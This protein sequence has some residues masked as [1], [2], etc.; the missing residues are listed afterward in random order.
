MLW[1]V[2]SGSSVHFSEDRS[3]FSE[4]RYFPEKERHFVQTANGTIPIQGTGTVFIK[5]W[6]NNT[7]DK[8]MMTIPCLHP[9]IYMLGIRIHLLSMGLLLK[10]NMH[11]K[12]E[13][14]TLQFIDAQSRKAKIVAISR[15]LSDMIYWVNLEVLSGEELTMHKSMH[16]MIMI[17]G[18]NDLDILGNSCLRNLN[19]VHENFQNQLRSL[20]SA[21]V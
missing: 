6:I 7:P 9:V 19:K 1:V 12:G 15:L 4:L 20:K 21:G 10:G 11:I 5:T 13:E 16:K 18:S 8:K 17:S 14:C 3:D 2:D